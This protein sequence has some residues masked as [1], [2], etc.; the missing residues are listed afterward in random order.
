[1]IEVIIILLAYIFGFMSGIIR[2]RTNGK[3]K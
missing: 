2:E 1:M 3:I